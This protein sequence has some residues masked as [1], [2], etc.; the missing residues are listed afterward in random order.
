[1]GHG[2]AAAPGGPGGS[3]LGHG[4]WGWD[5]GVLEVPEVCQA[6]ARG[7]ELLMRGVPRPSLS[8]SGRI[9]GAS[10]AAGKPRG[11]DGTDRPRHLATAREGQRLGSSGQGAQNR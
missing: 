10:A 7:G 3:A 8:P 9:R 11:D 4:T 5:C 2:A 6:Q 1:M